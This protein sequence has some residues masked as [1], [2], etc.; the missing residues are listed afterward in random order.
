M[1]ILGI[2]TSC[3]ETSAAV[4]SDD[5]TI[6]SNVIH[7]Q[8]AQHA[9][10]GGVVPEIASRSHIRHIDE[11]V[12]QAME[13]AQMDY[14]D[15]DAVAVTSG[16]GLIGGV[17]VGLMMAKAIAS[18][19]KIPL[20][21]INH[22]EG[23]ALTARLTN[24]V[25]FPFLLLLVSGG[26]CQI[27]EVA[28]ISDYKRLGSTLDDAL[29]EAFDKTAKMLGLGYPG[30][31]IVEKYAREGDENA[32]DLPRPLLNRKDCDFSFSGMKTGIYR[33]IEEKKSQN[34]EI[35]KD[36]KF[37][38]DLCASFQKAAGDVV[39]SKMERAISLFKEHHPHAD[40][41]VVAGGVAAN[42]YLRERLETLCAQHAMKLTAPP[43][44][45]CTDNAAMIAWAGIEHFKLGRQDDLSIQPRAR[46]P[47]AKQPA[48]I[49]FPFN[50]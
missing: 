45:L 39:V 37:I 20:I 14:K 4:V 47:L 23:H 26:H 6:I 43:L 28:N 35:L 31:P 33:L 9:P 46:W 27:L 36:K 22:L 41:I 7:S 12:R 15:L 1:K 38:A 34:P 17:I 21:G 19:A 25:P 32:Y 42:L 29:G 40:D 5:G 24:D 3:D 2:E 16:P 30:G 44:K 11:V 13:E 18:A 8:I 48:I 10:Y 50:K 49:Y